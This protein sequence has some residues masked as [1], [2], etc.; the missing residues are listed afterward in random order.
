MWTEERT[1]LKKIEKPKDSDLNKFEDNEKKEEEKKKPFVIKK[2]KDIK[3]QTP[4]LNDK[5]QK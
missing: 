3:P 5:A 1:E 2:N 4:D